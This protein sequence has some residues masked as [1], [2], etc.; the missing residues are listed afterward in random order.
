MF[1]RLPIRTIFYAITLAV[2]LFAPSRVL[3]TILL[4]EVQIEGEKAADEFVELYN[5][6]DEAVNL[7]GWSL[8]RKSVNDVTAKGTSLKTFGS[9]NSI[10]AKSYF[11]WANSGGTF[12]DLADTTTSSGLTDNNSLA[13]YDKSSTLIDSLTW[14]TGHALPFSP[15]QFGNPDEKESFT[16]DLDALSWSTT[17][18]TSPTNSKGETMPAEEEPPAPLPTDPMA[19]L[20]NEVFPNPKEKDDAGEFIELY[21]PGSATVDLSGWE[22]RDATATGKYVFPSG[23]TLLSLSYLVITDTD[24]TFS[25]NN[26]DETL[27]L[28]DAAK[29]LIHEVRYE[30]TKEGVSLNL[31]GDKLRGA[32]VPTPGTLNSENEI[33]TTRERV[34]KNG[35]RDFTI[36]FHARGKDKDGDSLKFTWNF[37]DGRKSY[38]ESTTHKYEKT[39]RY[40]VTLTTDDGIDTATETFEIKI[41]KYEAPKLRIVAFMPNPKGKDGELEWIEIENREKKSVNLNG[42]SIATG[43][44]KKSISNHPIKKD[45]S[46]P[47]KSVK[48][49]TRSHS[50]FTLGNERGFIELRAP[51]GEVIHD[52]KY[53]FDKPLEDD[54]VLKKEKGK[55]LTTVTPVEPVSPEET[56]SDDT[57]LISPTVEETLPITPPAE[58]ILEV[59][60]IEA[61]PLVKTEEVPALLD[62]SLDSVEEA[63]SETAPEVSAR[64]QSSGMRFL[65][66]FFGLNETENKNVLARWEDILNTVLNKWLSDTA[67]ATTES[68]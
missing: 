19:I 60:L 18:K 65:A 44:K 15:A 48:R 52:V 63:S 2:F 53:R 1:A 20:I 45:W 34:P 14:G 41:E 8:R 61:L 39:G 30:K 55:T 68:E 51:D 16:R 23:T 24:F 31:I 40:T 17:K 64:L 62:E 6:G 56:N 11:L 12:K 4:S 49:I 50:L 28:F 58:V 7:S 25:L 42:F 46:I 22:I 32:K 43:T 33:P 29:R 21:N 9:S 66:T 57:A 13:L 37:G 36:E 3:A 38:K 5:A 26:S 27:S 10:P 59:P 67:V 35:Y 47:G 54:V